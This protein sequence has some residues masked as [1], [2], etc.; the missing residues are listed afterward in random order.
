MKQ[1]LQH[2]DKVFFIE[3]KDK[4]SI[5]ARKLAYRETDK[6]KTDLQKNREGV[7]NITKQQLF[8]ITDRYKK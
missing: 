2:R 4:L 1:R 8:N 7:C 6:Y 3:N 5:G